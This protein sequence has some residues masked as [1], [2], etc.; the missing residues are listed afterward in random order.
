ML[1]SG[2]IEE[3]KDADAEMPDDLRAAFQSI[4]SYIWSELNCATNYGR[5]VKRREAPERK[6]ASRP[7]RP[8][9][10]AV[11]GEVISRRVA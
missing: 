8:A 2:L 1:A 7:A 10:V 3:M 4:K 5:L 11:N 9:L 6:R